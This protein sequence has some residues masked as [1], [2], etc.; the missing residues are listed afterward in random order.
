[1]QVMT[2]PTKTSE[3]KT[4]WHLVDVKGKILGRTATEIAKLLMGKRK[5]Y[6]AKN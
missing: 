6:I 5:P 2:R 3:I 4:D 1:M